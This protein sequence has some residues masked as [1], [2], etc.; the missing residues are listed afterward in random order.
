MKNLTLAQAK[1]RALKNMDAWT[2]VLLCD[3]VSLPLAYILAKYTG[4]S[5]FFLVALTLVARIAA[6]ISFWQ[7]WLLVGGLLAFA[8][9]VLDGTDGKLARILKKNETL[10][11]T[12]D[13]VLDQVGYAGMILGLALFILRTNN[14]SS[15][16]ILLIWTLLYCIHLSLTS[17]LYRLMNEAGV[18]VY[19]NATEVRK[20]YLSGIQIIDNHALKNLF[21]ALMSLYCWVRDKTAK[22]RMMAF[23]M[24]VDSQVLLFVI[25]PILAIP[26]NVNIVLTV[27][28]ALACFC[29]L[30]DSLAA[31]AR[32]RILV[33]LIV[34]IR[35]NFEVTTG[36][37]RVKGILTGTM[38]KG[39]LKEVKKEDQC[40]RTH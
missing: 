6:A 38:N 21:V 5:P 19:A 24:P 20:T 32:G 12:L 23:P 9:F 1:Q 2:E 39:S 27:C 36:D 15:L 29:L 26:L 31:A 8:G 22:L 34:K 35:T 7:G 17:T 18:S 4:V 30:P 25:A 11:G 14:G 16:V 33:A 37:E 13:F 3:P 28:I 10:R 40:D